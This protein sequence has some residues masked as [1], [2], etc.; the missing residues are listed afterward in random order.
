M[1]L[2]LPGC[3]PKDNIKRPYQKSLFDCISFVLS[4]LV[5]SVLCDN[6]SVLRGEKQNHLTTKDTK[7]NTKDTK[8]FWD[9]LLNFFYPRRISVADFLPIA[10]TAVIRNSFPVGIS[11][12]KGSFEI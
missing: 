5:Q 7:D 6:L 11:K 1:I 8:G 9:R 4:F 3:Y 2:L 10:S 12:I